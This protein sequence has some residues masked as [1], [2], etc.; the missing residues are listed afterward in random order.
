MSICSLSNALR[1]FD[2]HLIPSTKELT[3]LIFV[4]FFRFSLSLF[5]FPSRF[6]HTHTQTQGYCHNVHRKPHLRHGSMNTSIGSASFGP[7]YDIHTHYNTQTLVFF[8]LQESIIYARTTHTSIHAP[9]SFNRYASASIC[10]LQQSWRSVSGPLGCRTFR[11]QESLHAQKYVLR[12][13]FLHPE[14]GKS[15]YILRCICTKHGWQALNA[16]IVSYSTWDHRFTRVF[17]HT[18]LLSTTSVSSKQY[19]WRALQENNSL[20]RRAALLTCFVVTPWRIHLTWT[21]RMNPRTFTRLLEVSVFFL[22]FT[23]SIKVHPLILISHRTM[24]IP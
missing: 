24:H 14:S 4:C 6:R 16:R 3:C 21:R 7:R 17:F 12:A 10:S 19:W 23:S 8:F 18:R 5:R 22:H 2:L 11:K 13:C 1:G 20:L 15:A 9:S